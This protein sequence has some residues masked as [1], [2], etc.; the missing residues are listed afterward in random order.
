MIELQLKLISGAVLERLSGGF[1][2]GGMKHAVARHLEE[3][4]IDRAGFDANLCEVTDIEPQEVGAGAARVPH[5]LGIVLDNQDIPTRGGYDRMK[6]EFHGRLLLG[7]GLENP[8]LTRSQVG[9]AKQFE[10]DFID[11]TTFTSS[12][13]TTL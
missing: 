8:H 13:T 11:P 1:Q 7:H 2:R 3:R 10:I 6:L 9:M 12:S 4:A 5:F